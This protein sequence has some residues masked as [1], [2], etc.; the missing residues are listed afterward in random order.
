M[1]LQ[2]DSKFIELN[3]FDP[4]QLHF[5]DGAVRIVRYCPNCG[6]KVETK[7]IEKIY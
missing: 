2:I 1:N 5:K 7:R 3:N 4:P 6:E